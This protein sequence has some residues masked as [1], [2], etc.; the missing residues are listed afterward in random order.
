VGSI[1]TC[2]MRM[3]PLSHLSTRYQH[4]RSCHP[5]LCALYFPSLIMYLAGAPELIARK[6]ITAHTDLVFAVAAACGPIYEPACE[7]CEK[8]MAWNDA[9]PCLDPS[10]VGRSATNA[11]PS[12]TPRKLEP[13][14]VQRYLRAAV[15]PAAG[16]HIH[17]DPRRFRD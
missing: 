9:L 1:P 7:D 8:S 4:Q 11:V 15:T 14:S 13:C 10:Q 6:C 16:E 12:Q 5:S 17:D 3:T 2:G